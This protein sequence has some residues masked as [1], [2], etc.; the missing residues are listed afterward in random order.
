MQK[1]LKQI[2]LYWMDV[3]GSIETYQAALPAQ[4]DDAL[5]KTF[6]TA[7]IATVAASWMG[8]IFH[9]LIF[10]SYEKFRCIR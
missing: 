6:V 8:L 10:L 3:N 9:I 4:Q 7:G 5:K 2:D 1:N